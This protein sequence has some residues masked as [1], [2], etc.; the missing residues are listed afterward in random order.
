MANILITIRASGVF[1]RN[2]ALD[3][4]RRF[5]QRAHLAHQRRFKRF[6]RTALQIVTLRGPLVQRRLA[7]AFRVW[8][9]DN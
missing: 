1:W 6:P 9:R 4:Q 3:Q 2:M 5:P 8:N 7:D